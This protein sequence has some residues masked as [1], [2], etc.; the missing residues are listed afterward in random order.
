MALLTAI[1]FLE[2]EVVTGKWLR[3]TIGSVFLVLALLW[4]LFPFGG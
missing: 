1:T 4:Y 3:L 2:R